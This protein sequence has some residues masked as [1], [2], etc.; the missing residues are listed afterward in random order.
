M[1][2]TVPLGFARLVQRAPGMGHPHGCSG[3]DDQV[4]LGSEPAGLLSASPGS[5]LCQRDRA[6]LSDMDWFSAGGLE[7]LR[8]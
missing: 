7:R 4:P 6:A 5:G 2:P 1:K 3:K 8:P